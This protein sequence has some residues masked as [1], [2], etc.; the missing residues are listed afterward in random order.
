MISV[1]IPTFNGQKYIA[2][3]LDSILC[4]L[5]ESDEII[6][7]DDSSQDRT[8]EII[9]NYSDPRIN[10]ILNCN[11]KSPIF[12]LQNALI[13]AKGDYIF[14]ADQDDVW[15]PGKVEAM[16]QYLQHY[17]IVV[18]DCT[19][20]DSDGNVIAESFF[21]INHSKKGFIHN[22]IKNSY[23]GCCIAFRKEMLR[24]Y[25][26]FPDTIAMHDIWI[27][28]LSEIFGKPH[29]IS[30]KFV[31]YRRHDAN[32]TFSGKRS[33]YS[34]LYRIKYRFVF[35]YLLFFRAMKI[36]FHTQS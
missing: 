26:P 20:I 33:Q 27:G 28:L 5:T 24:Y 29:F 3:Q 6:I 32:L 35:L 4:Q 10:L 30:D 19:L 18:S 16:T 13:H 14:L 31:L 2:Q 22:F 1:C 7:S 8:I 25:L 9:N 12:N 11:F 17:N 21:V 15:L 34:L 36:L 23:L